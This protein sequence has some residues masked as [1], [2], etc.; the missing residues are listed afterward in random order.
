MTTPVRANEK[1]AAAD[2]SYIAQ[3][4]AQG[5]YPALYYPHNLHFLYAAASEEGR[6]SEAIDAAK[7]LMSA[8][9]D[10]SFKEYPMLEEFRPVYWMALTRFGHWDDVLAE[11]A[12]ASELHYA[13][14][15]WHY[16][17]GMAYARTSKLGEAQGEYDSLHEFAAAPELKDLKLPQRVESPRSAHDRRARSRRRDRA[18]QGECRR[19]DS[20]ATRSRSHARLASLHRAAPL[21]FSCEARARCG[22]A[23]AGTARTR[24]NGCSATTSSAIATTAGLSMGSP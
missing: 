8:A 18:P 24:P 21:V 20:R 3:C 19:G 4:R 22:P 15:L 16:A 10:A 13:T 12:P 14:A 9:P 1:A 17:R 6:S 11:A 7:R 23:A 2:E 5:F